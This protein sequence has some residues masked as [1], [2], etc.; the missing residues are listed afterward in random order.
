MQQLRLKDE[1]LSHVSHELRSPLNAIHQFVTILLDRLSGELNLEQ[2]GNL[3]VVLRNVKQLQSMIN[4][5]LEVSGVQAG[6]LKIEL[7]CTSMSDALGY[8]IKTLQGAAAAKGIMLSSDS[9]G[10]LPSI[11]A[12]PTRLRQILIILAENAIKFT[13]QNGTVKIQARILDDDPSLL[14]L[15]V[16]DSGC[17]IESRWLRE[18]LNGSSKLRC[19]FVR[20]QRSRL[21]PVHL[22]RLG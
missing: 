18:F 17:G 2:S 16:S 20:S 4:D 8:T 12:D 11:C 21:G 7:Q 5:L 3:E 1:F 6:K 19:R 15:E 22:Q 14:L 10:K 9:V 13:P